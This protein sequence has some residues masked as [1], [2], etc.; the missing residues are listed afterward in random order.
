M[1]S[2]DLNEI[3]LLVLCFISYGIYFFLPKKFTLQIRILSLMWG[4]ATG[5]LFD[6]TIGG[7]MID[8]YMQNDTNAYEIFDFVYYLLYAPFG[9]FFFYF[10]DLFHINRRTF[11]LYI[12]GWSII[13][14]CA[15]WV[16][17]L[18]HIIS[19]QKG[20]KLIY[21]FPI[22]LFT[23]TLTGFFYCYITSKEKSSSGKV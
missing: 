19:L 15:Q 1:G 3:S 20:Y 6:F 16:F 7:G 4:F 22:F 13:G 17:T 2:F 21:S 23:Q 10:Y 5:V 14:L 18:L 8:L 12:T 11:I 9:Y